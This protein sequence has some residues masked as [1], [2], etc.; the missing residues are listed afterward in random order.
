MTVAWLLN[1]DA[2]AELASYRSG[3]AARPPGGP[4]RRQLEAA[5]AQLTRSRGDGGLV[6][7]GDLVVDTKALDPGEELRCP[8]AGRGP[9][10]LTPLAWSATPT[11]RASMASLGL[12]LEGPP[13][14][15]LIEANARETFAGVDPLPGAAV[16]DS[17]AALRAVVERSPLPRSGLGVSSQPAW[18]LRRSLSCAG[19]GRLIAEGWS[20]GVEAWGAAALAEG[21]IE[22]QPLVDIVEEY[23]THGWIQESGELRCGAPLCWRP[24]HGAARRVELPP[25]S[26]RDLARISASGREVGEILRGIGYAGPF[27]VDAFRWRP[28]A[29]EVRLQV[30]TD[31]NARL[32]LHFA[33]GAPELLPP[34]SGHQEHLAEG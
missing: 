9:G 30:V 11:A 14:E 6:G 21:P 5:R 34:T 12:E 13:V 2:E 8:P 29:G 15:V 3:R 1:L 18:V 19:R 24:A 23:S 33:R 32:T 25:P 16:A 4:A 10:E 7:P 31:V 27:G 26:D 20:R 22:V 28:A 17:M